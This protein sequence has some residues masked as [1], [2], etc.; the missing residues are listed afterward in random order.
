MTIAISHYLRTNSILFAEL[1]F[2]YSETFGNFESNQIRNKPNRKV[3]RSGLFI[4]EYVDEG[5]GAF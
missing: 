4:D 3:P 5:G 2:F 1:L